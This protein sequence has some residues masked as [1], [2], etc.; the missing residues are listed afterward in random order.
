MSGNFWTWKCRGNGEA[1][2]QDRA[3]RYY[4]FRNEQAMVHAATGFTKASFRMKTL[5]CTTSVGPGATN[6]VTGAAVA[7]VNRL[8]VLLLPG[9]VSARRNVARQFC[10]SWNL[11][12]H[13]TFPSTIALSPF[14]GIGTDST[15]RAT[16]H[17]PSRGHARPDVTCGDGRCYHQLSARRP[18]RSIRIS[19]EFLRERVWVIPRNRCDP[20]A[21][22]EAAK[23]MGVSKKPLTVIGRR[24]DLFRSI[25]RS[26][27]LC[28]FDRHTGVRNASR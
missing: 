19:E 13:K 21:L 27:E 4:L 1:L 16:A 7:T 8:P 18:G 23:S 17:F 2:E 28:P 15:S 6:M 20:S 12:R 26:F 3:L 5:V 24:R 9:D 11:R 25:R 14:R 22:D 10:N